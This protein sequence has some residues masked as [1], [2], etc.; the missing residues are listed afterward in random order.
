MK[1][2]SSAI[3]AVLVLCS[4]AAQAADDAAKAD[5]IVR[6]KVLTSFGGCHDCHTPKT[7]TAQGPEF[8]MTRAM[9]G[10]PATQTNP[11]VD[12]RALDPKYWMLMANDLQTFVGPWGISYAANLTPDDQTGIGLWTEELFVKT[13]RTGKHLG[14][15]RPLLPPMFIEG[16]K[17]MPDSDL[18]AIY[19]YLRSLPPIKNP[20]PGPVAP[21][22]VK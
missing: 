22:D 8:D 13:L 20:V 17:L 21:P 4:V 15:G 7:F 14:E 5:M 18:K 11:P 2:L 12:K 6:G 9:S 16:F 10:R 19:A 3:A 1:S